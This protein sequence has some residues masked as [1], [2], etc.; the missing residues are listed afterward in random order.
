M[1]R[2]LLQS[3]EQIVLEWRNHEITRQFS[4]NQALITVKEHRQW[5]LSRCRPQ[6]SK[7]LDFIFLDGEKPIGLCRIDQIDLKIPEI[8]ILLNPSVWGMGY[9]NSILGMS[10][11]E[12]SRLLEISGY[13][14]IIH[15]KNI[16]SKKLFIKH[17]FTEISRNKDFHEYRLNTV[18][19]G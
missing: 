19:S 4:R 3:D 14:A 9:G 2:Q 6:V 11:Q 1:M 7:S 13:F 5:I 18:P 10:L 12:S 8:S 15:R 17:G 16:A